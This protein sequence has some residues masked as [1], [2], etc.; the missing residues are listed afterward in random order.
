MFFFF[1]LEREVERLIAETDVAEKSNEVDCEIPDT[2][3]YEVEEQGLGLIINS[4]V[5]SVSIQSECFVRNKKV[6]TLDINIEP[7][8]TMKTKGTQT[9]LTSEYLSRKLCPVN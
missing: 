9:L 5:Q 4:N 7:S 3:F 2:E 6:Q 1:L 8:K